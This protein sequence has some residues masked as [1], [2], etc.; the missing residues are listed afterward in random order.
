MRKRNKLYTVNKWNQP[1]FAQGI[2]REHQNIFDGLDFSYLNNVDAGSLGSL[3]KTIDPSK[4]TSSEMSSWLPKQ[5]DVPVGKVGGAGKIGNVVGA[6]GGVVGGAANKIISGG[7]SS[8]AGNAVSSIGNTVGSAISTINPVVGGIVSAASGIIGG[9]INALWGMKTDQKKLRAANEGTNYLNSFVSDASTFDDIQGPN[10]VANVQNAYKGGVF[11]KGKA[12]RK[13]AA[14]RAERANAESWANRS[15]DN[16]INN[17]AETQMDNML[18]NYAAFGGPLG[19]M[20]IQDTGAIDYGFMSDYLVTKNRMAD[21]KNKITGTVF[22]NIPSTPINT[23]ESGGGIH[24]KKSHRGLFT[25]EAKAHGMGVQEFASHV[26]ANKDKYSPEVVKRANFA[27]NAAK[28]ALGGDMQTNGA[29]FTDG[30]TIIGAGGSHEE[31]PYDGV[32]VGVSRENGQPNLVEEGETIFDDYVFSQ[33]I[34]ADAKTKKK[35]HVGKKTEISYADLSKKLE[36]ESLERPNDPISQNGLKKQLHDLADEQERQKGEEMQDAF[37]QLPPE[38]QQAIMQ[39]IAMQEQ[40]AEETQ[41]MQNEEQLQNAQQEEQLQGQQDNGEQMVEEPNMEEENAEQINACGGK[42]NRFDK[43]GNMKRKIY[44]LLKTP[45]D[46][47]FNKWAEDHKIDKIT[48][49]EN[50]LK[51]KAFVEALGKD[52]PMLRDAI[53]RGYDFGFYIPNE[54]GKLT[55]DFVHGGWGK[56]DYNAW[57]GSTDAAWKEAVKKG[58]VKKGMKSEEIGKALAQT[59][60]YKRGSDW[61]KENEKNRLFYLQQILNSKDA[62]EAARQYA[63]RY[64]DNNGWLKDAKRDYQTIFEDP[65]GTGVRNTHPGTYWK[66][67]DEMLR[68]KVT[69]NFVVNDDGTVDEIVG[70]IPKEW[71]DAGSYNWKDAN[72]DYEYNYYKR[73]I[74]NVVTPNNG[75]KTDDEEYEPVH[76]PTWGRTAGL[77]GPV[78]GLGMQALGIGKPDYSGMDASLEIA[79]GSPALAHAQFIGNRLKYRPMDIWYEQ[80]RMDANSRATDRAILNNASPMGT[81]MAGL[82]ANGYNSQIAD[83]ELYRKA[84]EYNDAQRQRVEEFNRGTDMYNANA[85]NQTSVTNAQI[86]NNNRQLRA[87]MQMDAARQRMAADAAWNQGI[88][89]N[90]NGLFAGLGAWGKENT[91]HNMIAD[92]AADGLFGT[93]SDKQNI[94]KTYIRKK[95]AA[96]GGKIN[97]KKRGLTF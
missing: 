68:N 29:D 53:S 73:P 90:V 6:L 48:D 63:A 7:L 38:Q 61:L 69:G 27:R 10:A 36:K 9:G 12:R 16:N 50:V 78:V 88:Y 20:P 39:Q 23:F 30:L 80:N 60:A 92:M 54:N 26:L 86:A 49:W 1:L 41:Q 85:A 14:L 3:N 22:D 18:A 59:D 32:Q 84:L 64:V 72:S 40:Q 57:N 4:I 91:Q 70:D 82:L 25:K 11:K 77:L 44:N 19:G 87:Q 65:N 31:N 58:L 83:G 37:D 15:V 24:I 67:P 62:P 79:N 8:G 81:K 55:F 45:T 96:C 5:V 93:M 75:Q 43:G 94:G 74:E 17:I 2:D 28:F 51:N 35:F 66:T 71:N 76:K 42:M 46:R 52:N 89:G 97:R 47:E 21:M 95:K 13:N 34:K 56:E 33:R